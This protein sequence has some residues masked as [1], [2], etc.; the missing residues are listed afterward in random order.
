MAGGGI[1]VGQFSQALTSSGSVVLPAYLDAPPRA[2]LW[3]PAGNGH[4]GSGLSGA[5]GGGGGEYAEEP[6]LGGVA[7]GTTL[8]ITIVNGSN[9][10]VAGGAVTVTAHFGNS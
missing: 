9:A 4:A 5:G 2:Q 10:T 7:P 8:T 1:L 3:A 6:A